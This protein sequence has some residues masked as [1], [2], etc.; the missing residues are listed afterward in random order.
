MVLNSVRATSLISK[1]SS[2]SPSDVVVALDVQAALEA[3][4]DFLGVVLEALERFELAGVDHHVV[5]QQAQ[6]RCDDLAG[7][8]HTAGDRAD[9]AD[10]EH[11]ADLGRT[12]DFLALLGCQHAGHGAFTSS[13]AS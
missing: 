1:N 10:H 6:R 11:G 9:L 8:D 3:F 2:W 5:A 7:G 13:T 12:D 4:L